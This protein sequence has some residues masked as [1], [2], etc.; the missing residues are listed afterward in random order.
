MET[1]RIR[2]QEGYPNI[3]LGIK[4]NVTRDKKGHFITKVPIYKMV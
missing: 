1:A 4:T 3:R 2:K